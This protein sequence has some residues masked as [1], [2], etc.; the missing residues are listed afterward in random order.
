[1][2]FNFIFFIS[3]LIRLFLLGSQFFPKHP[4]YSY[5]LILSEIRMLISN[6]I[7]VVFVESQKCCWWTFWFFRIHYFTTCWRFLIIAWLFTRMI[8][9][10]YFFMSIRFFIFFVLFVIIV[11][12]FLF[13]LQF[14]LTALYFRILKTI[15]SL[16]LFFWI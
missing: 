12:C 9:V 1:M 16:F 5:Q 6:F 8:F 3:L 10:F 14:T 13:L 7:N 4:S 11:F 2:I 15:F